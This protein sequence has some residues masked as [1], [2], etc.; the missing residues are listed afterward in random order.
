[1][2]PRTKPAEDHEVTIEPL[3]PAI[4]KMIEKTQLKVEK[5][6]C[7]K[8]WVRTSGAQNDNIFDPTAVCERTSGKYPFELVSLAASIWHYNV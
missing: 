3:P 8:C 4:R 7:W 5:R 6:R 1:M 2:P